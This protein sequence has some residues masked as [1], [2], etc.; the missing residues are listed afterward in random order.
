MFKIRKILATPH[1]ESIVAA[2]QLIAV[3]AWNRT[4]KWAFRDT[5]RAQKERTVVNGG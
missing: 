5:I 4:F 3:I 2:R 1:I